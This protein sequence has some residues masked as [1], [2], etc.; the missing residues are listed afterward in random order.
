MIDRSS[1]SGWT[2][3][4][5]T[6]GGLPLS[7][8]SK[9]FWTPSCPRTISPSMNVTTMFLCKRDMSL[10]RSSLLTA[11]IMS[12]RSLRS[13]AWAA[14]S[15][16]SFA[17]RAAAGMIERP[18]IPLAKRIH[19]DWRMARLL[20]RSNGL[21]HVP[22]EWSADGRRFGLLLRQVCQPIEEIDHQPI[23]RNECV[24]TVPDANEP[25]GVVPQEALGEQTADPQAQRLK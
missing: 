12:S 5:C 2:E 24:G 4:D 8:E 13:S 19:S 7:L 6:T 3:Y 25:V 20:G 16:A 14:S 18:A 11:S 23:G 22:A 9:Y 21:A 10:A 1:T 17:C 15:G